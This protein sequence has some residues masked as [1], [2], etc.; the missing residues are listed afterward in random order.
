MASARQMHCRQLGT[1]KVETTS[2]HAI[3][4]D[5]LLW[6]PLR[7]PDTFSRF[8]LFKGKKLRHRQKLPFPASFLVNPWLL[9]VT[10]GRIAEHALNLH[11]RRARMRTLSCILASKELLENS[12]VLS[13]LVLESRPRPRGG[14]SMWARHSPAD[15]G[16]QASSALNRASRGLQGLGKVSMFQRS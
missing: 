12:S 4:H 6:K 9:H 13:P 15:E 14:S 8:H 7:S 10:P 3:V 1:K 5:L 16:N 11:T 2:L